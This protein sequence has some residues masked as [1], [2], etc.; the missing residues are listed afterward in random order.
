MKTGRIITGFASIFAILSLN[1]IA[2]EDEEISNYYYND[3]DQVKVKII[4][5]GE[6]IVIDQDISA[7]FLTA[8]FK[9]EDIVIDQNFSLDLFNDCFEDIEI[10]KYVSADPFSGY[11]I[12][13]KGK[14]VVTDDDKDIKSISP[15][16]YLHI[17]KMAF[18]NERSIKIESDVNGNLTNKYYEGNNE[19]PFDTK[20]KEW[21]AEI[22]IDI[23][24]SSG[25][26]AEERVER[27]Y[28]QKGINALIEEIEAISSS[29]SRE[30]KVM[31]IEIEMYHHSNKSVR[32]LYYQILI[33]EIQL[34]NDDLSELIPY[35]SSI[36][37]NSTKGTLV[38]EILY[39][40]SLSVENL[41][42]LLEVTQTLD[43][44]TERGSVL[45]VL[46]PKLPDHARVTDIYFEIINN[47]EINSE[48]G[49]VIKHLLNTKSDLSKSTY[50]K[51][52]ESI[53]N[54][55]SEREKGALLIR[56]AK[57]L[58]ED[59]GLMDEFYNIVDNMDEDYYVLKGE[60]LT[61]VSERGMPDNI[62]KADKNIVLRLLKSSEDLI[63]N[64]QRGLNLRRVNK[65]YTNDLEVIDAYFKVIKGFSNKLEEYNV[66]LD[67]IEKNKLDNETLIKI[68]R[69]LDDYMPTYQ[70]AAG[71]VL[72]AT[73][74][75]LPNDNRVLE[76]FFDVVE[77]MDQNSTIEEILRLLC[78][79]K[80]L[81]SNKD[82][83]VKIIEASEIIDVDIET[84][85]VLLNVADILP[86]GQNDLSYVYKSAAKTIK[87]EYLINKV[88]QNSQ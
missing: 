82:F 68:Y 71:A 34:T 25:V 79:Q 22:L 63:S 9:D 86:K 42:K 16:G 35:L 20:G 38:R 60:I 19:I 64:S 80:S 29:Y 75:Q 84:A 24:R 33:N 81:A 36:R 87:S 44:N 3:N 85:S 18:G 5:N 49:N 70:H 23:I 11:E 27:I 26:G 30:T 88:L 46:N 83:I 67:L 62:Y 72:R 61:A 51:M 32:N 41:V 7:D 50:Y 40:Y 43:Y 53:S 2:Q 17:E 48:K 54:F 8:K 45:R 78:K 4:N 52:L 47:M 13:Y 37:S 31:F 56:L 10:E 69:R 1:I 77:E 76:Y 65:M 21:L 66:L 14:I 6:E 59:K 73:I 39:K 74:N 57:I 12:K 58:P 15:G 55:S 28:K